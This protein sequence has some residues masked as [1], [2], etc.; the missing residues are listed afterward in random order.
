[1]DFGALPPEIN[2]ARMYGG[3]GSSPLLQAAAAWNGTAVELNATAASFESVTTRLSSDPWI[4]PASLSMVAAAQPLLAWLTHAAE[5]SALAATQAMASVAAYEAA[6]AMTVPPSEVVANRVRLAE[7]IATNVLGQNGARI[8][9]TEARYGEM[10]AQD[11]TA[12]YT[13]A[14]SSAVSMRLDPLARPSPATNPAGIAN[15]AAAVGQAA[16]S[17]SAQDVGMSNLIS[18]VP[19][20]VMSLASPAT[21][22]ALVAELGEVIEYFVYLDLPLFVESVFHGLGAI[23]DYSG[24]AVANALAPQSGVVTA[25][26]AGP[27]TAA[28]AFTRTSTSAGTGATPP[29]A[30]V[31][32]AASVGRLSVPATWS[33]ADPA[34]ICGTE[35]DGTDWSVPEEDGLVGVTRSG[36]GMVVAA[37][38]ARVGAG[39]RYGVKP[40][41]M[42]K[43]NLV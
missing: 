38:G 32:A 10:W 20:A 15:Q 26:T 24:A 12:M 17:S 29:V 22:V 33:S 19:N 28:A 13:Y 18:S 9:A 1:M 34:V 14:A 3:A 16:T 5:C 6:F 4:G 27:G 2:S 39:P 42:P 23:A 7:L 11:A 41:V 25:G 36:A 35:L 37:N 40:V 30:N 21:A 43:Q 31:G 8:A